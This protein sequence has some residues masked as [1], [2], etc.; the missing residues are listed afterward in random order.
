LQRREN[1]ANNQSDVIKEFQKHLQEWR[2][3]FLMSQKEA[4]KKARKRTK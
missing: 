4:G 3:A 2:L 1:S